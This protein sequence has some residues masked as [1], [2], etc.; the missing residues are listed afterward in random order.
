MGLFSFLK[1]AGANLFKS[2]EEPKVA[3]KTGTDSAEVI[4]KQRIILLKGIVESHGLEVQ[5]FDLDLHADQVTVYGQVASQEIK[6]KVILTLG[7]VAGI[8]TVDDRL[9]VV[10]T[11]TSPPVREAQ[12]HEVKKG[13]TLSKIAKNYYGDAMKYPV[14]FEANKP[15]LKSPDLIYP[16]QVLRIPHLD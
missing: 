16:G 1:N 5:D 13:D 7:N 10:Q 15:M 8:A 3:E 14:I 12:F 6:E 9:S 4:R 2:K 11:E